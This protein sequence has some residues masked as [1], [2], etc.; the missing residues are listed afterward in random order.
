MVDGFA[1]DELVDAAD[2]FIEVAEPELGHELAHL[3]GDEAH[4]VD[5]VVGIAGEFF[6]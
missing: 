4:E 3:G 1:H 5:H 2:H 6:A